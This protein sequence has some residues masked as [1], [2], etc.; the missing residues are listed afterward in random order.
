MGNF[1]RGFLID[2]SRIDFE[3][4]GKVIG[5]FENSVGLS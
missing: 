3:K 1:E 4:V 2:N 5:T